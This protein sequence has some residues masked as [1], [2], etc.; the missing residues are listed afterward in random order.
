M[1]VGLVFVLGLSALSGLVATPAPV[2]AAEEIA[3][4]A[5]EAH[6]GPEPL[7]PGGR[8]QLSFQPHRA[9]GQRFPGEYFIERFTIK[10]VGTARTTPF[11]Y[12]VAVG[13]ANGAAWWAGATYASVF[14]DTSY[15]R[16]E[17]LGYNSD[18]TLGYWNWSGR[19]SKDWSYREFS[20]WVDGK[21]ADSPQPARNIM[22]VTDNLSA[23]GLKHTLLTKVQ[24]AN[25]GPAVTV[26]FPAT[27][28]VIPGNGAG[29]QMN[30]TFLAQSALED[31]HFVYPNPISGVPYFGTLDTSE[32]PGVRTGYFY[33]PLGSLRT[34]QIW[35]YADPDA[36]LGTCKVTATFRATK[37]RKNVT[38]TAYIRV[39]N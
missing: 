4:S 32:C 14:G 35:L 3:T 23:S 6:G 15:S 34:A 8:I 2:A 37:A 36:K 7:P 1:L 28:K 11:N 38:M 31:W 20:F 9:N 22:T 33:T 30:L 29:T 24:T 27:N 10:D 25:Y 19:L 5:I 12:T 21:A 18:Y 39:A 17:F 13:G 16:L 26:A